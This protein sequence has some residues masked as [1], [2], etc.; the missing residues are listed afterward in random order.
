MNEKTS[1]AI[2]PVCK[3]SIWFVI[4]CALAFALLGV[5][6][7]G[8]WIDTGHK[9]TALITWNELTPTAKAKIIELLKRH[10]RYEKDLLDGLPTG[11]DEAGTARYAL[12][13][14][15][16]WPDLVRGPGHPMHFVANH[17]DWHYLNIPYAID[18]QAVPTTRATTPPTTSPGPQNVVEALE[19]NT[20]DLKDSVATAEDRAIALC[21]M[22]HLCG[23]IHH[24]LHACTLYS[25]QYPDGD[26][27]GNAIIVLRDP[28]YSNSR[29]NLH[30]IWD[31]LPGDYQ[32]LDWDG[33][34]ADGLRS[35]PRFSRARLKDFLAVKDFAAWASESHQLAIDHAYLGGT[36]KGITPAQ[37][38]ADPKIMI[39]GVPKGYIEQAEQVV[40]QRII[41][42]G[43][44]A[45][46][47]LNSIF[48]A[49]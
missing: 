38:K 32:S 23:D 46:D 34:V 12:A 21:W 4:Q 45:A 9:I 10:P 24:P 37:L 14:A 18:N 49:R 27:G 17:P 20:K 31:S 33:Y 16:C 1:P 42:A 28:P 35:D 5:S 39:P 25:A 26:Q 2:R 6:D 43:Y 44:R 36:L 19:K 47:L 29:Q 7:A 40:N 8:A 22:L 15:A 48:D 30:F 41:L 11:T 3:F 13:N